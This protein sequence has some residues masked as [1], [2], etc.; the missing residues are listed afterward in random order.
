MGRRYRDESWL[1]ERYDAEGRTQAEIANECGVS[2][3]CIR[4]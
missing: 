4:K 3:S 2:P 1:H